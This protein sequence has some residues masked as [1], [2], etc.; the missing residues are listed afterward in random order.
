MIAAIVSMLLHIPASPSGF[1]RSPL[2]PV[3]T[4]GRAA[5]QSVPVPEA[6]VRGLVRDESGAVI[7]GAVVFVRSPS[8]AERY[9]V[10]GVEGQFQLAGFSSGP[11][12][13]IVRASGFGDYRKTVIAATVPELLEVVLAA[14]G[15]SEEVTVAATRVEQRIGDVAASINVL[16]R[17]DIR[18][19]PAVVADDVL[20]QLPAFSLFRRTSSLA[21][22]P[23]TQ[24]VSLRGIGSSGV[25]RTLVLLD[26][27]PL[28]DPFGGWVYWSRV[29]I[30]GA[31]RIEVVESASSSVYGNY[32]MGGLINVMTPTPSP[33]TFELRTQ[34]GSRRSPKLDLH[35]SD[36]FGRLGVAVDVNAF[37]TNGYQ[38]VVGS[39]RGPVDANSTVT[40]KNASI[41]FDYAASDRVRA[42]LRTGYFSEQRDNGKRNSFTPSVEE[43]NDTSVTSTSGGVRL[44]LPDR[45]EVT[46]TVFSDRGTFQTNY[47]TVPFTS[48]VRTTGL[49]TL[50][51]TVP[52]TSAG[53]VV[54]WTRPLNAR[55]VLTGGFDWRWVDGESDEVEYDAL[56]GTTPVLS[57]ASG[58]T[59]QSVG[60]YIQDLITPTERTSVTLSA[61][62]D[63]WSNSDGF[64]RETN[65][66]T[67]L[68]SALGNSAFPH[69]SDA[70]ISPRAAVR[71][72]LSSTR[73]VWASVGTGFR[74]PTLNELY[75][76]A[77]VGSVQILANGDL[78]PE[79]LLSVEG[80]VSLEPRPNM[81][82]RATLFDSRVS[83]P[84]S[85]VTIN[86]SGADVTVLR[87]NLGRTR[88]WG[89]ESDVEYRI[90]TTW[91]VI[92][93]Y[94]F[95]SS[96]VTEYSADPS[97]GGK[98]SEV[99]AD[100]TLVG[101]YLVQVPRH[102]AS[103]LLAWDDP[104]WVE[105]SISVQ[106]TGN[107][108]DDDQNIRGIPGNTTAGLPGYAV[109]SLS[110]SR[111]LDRNVEMFLGAQNLFNQEYFVATLPSLV[112]PPRM[113]T[114]GLRL[115]FR[116][117]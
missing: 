29:P 67:G 63:R 116:G 89:L 62:V 6:P 73:S 88:S 65:V 41:K 70:V 84:V 34:Y 39:D 59:Q 80:G 78:G 107:Q 25:S 102:R 115:T 27:V 109:V 51:Q 58:G 48:P 23:A 8:G 4:Q 3:A 33:R 20:R 93:A 32:A 87:L 60:G 94:L 83:H 103:V 55:H 16:T 10:T 108:F 52:S 50:A 86:R 38:T 76:S 90:G 72:H 71:H 53:T 114:G 75:R 31:E 79:R 95:G 19:S 77:R 12:E 35:A 113:I 56:T 64:N 99:S 69:R 40:F 49:L 106:M 110:V 14:A 57:R 15:Q 46:V 45:S 96:R 112:G 9:T 30:D 2:S 97:L 101:K 74:A 105:A 37:D 66:Q 7:A 21:A 92:G 98:Y 22:H 61:R 5:F 18:Q 54:Q 36:V 24:G 13:I 11:F 117:R 26:G 28:N 47:I 17:D 111:R 100:P 43:G 42:F 68:L 44:R 85:N 81:V 104:R 82:V 1:A 91:R